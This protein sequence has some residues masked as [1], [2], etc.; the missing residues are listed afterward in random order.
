MVKDFN[1][2][3]YSLKLSEYDRDFERLVLE[4]G[5]ESE[6][7]KSDVLNFCKNKNIF[8]LTKLNG[9]DAVKKFQSFVAYCCKRA[10]FYGL[11]EAGDDELYTY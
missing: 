1:S 2:F 11:G 6:D 7:F 8:D 3:I 10:I 4:I 9:E 5:E